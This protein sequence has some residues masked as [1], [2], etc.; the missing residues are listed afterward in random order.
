MVQHHPVSGSP[1]FFHSNMNKWNL[2]VASVWDKHPRLWEVITP[3]GWSATEGDPRDVSPLLPVASRL[4]HVAYDP[5]HVAWLELQRLR[6][7]PWLEEYLLRTGGGGPDEVERH[8]YDAAPHE[9][10]G[11]VLADHASGQYKPLW[12]DEEPLITDGGRNVRVVMRSPARGGDGKTGKARVRVMP[13]VRS[14][15]R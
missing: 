8:V 7:A 1:L 11:M 10:D 6:C 5:E 15:N 12:Q 14:L 4:R 3:S 2:R 13:A 9:H